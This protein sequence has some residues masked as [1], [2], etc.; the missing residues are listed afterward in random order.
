MLFAV[1]VK[2]SQH[3]VDIRSLH[4]YKKNIVA[5]CCNVLYVLGRGGKEGAVEKCPTCR[6]K[7]M[8]FRVQQIA[9]GMMQQIQSPCNDCMGQ[10]ERIN[11][12]LRCKTC[13]GKKTVRERKILEVHVDKG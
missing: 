4:N 2:V 9:P 8:L 11:P 1:N 5:C 13:V 10:G 12:K 6:G 3:Q 7:G